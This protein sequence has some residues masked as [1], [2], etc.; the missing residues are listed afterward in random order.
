MLGTLF[1]TH[2]TALSHSLTDTSYT[3]LSLTP[4]C[5]CFWLCLSLSHTFF[6][7]LPQNIRQISI[8]FAG[9][10]LAMQKRAKRKMKKKTICIIARVRISLYMVFTKK[11]CKIS[12]QWL[13]F[14]PK[15]TY[16]LRATRTFFIYLFIFSSIAF[17]IIFFRFGFFDKRY[18]VNQIHF[19]LFP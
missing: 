15:S 6:F 5:G 17:W 18:F 19:S 12:N 4:F 2:L 3:F 7:I 9:L 16:T 11:K 14:S 13:S 1:G 10:N 8:W